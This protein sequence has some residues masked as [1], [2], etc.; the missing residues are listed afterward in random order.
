MAASFVALRDE[1]VR[2][3]GD[4]FAGVGQRLDLAHNLRACGLRLLGVGAGGAEGE[5]DDG[6]LRFDGSVE[7]RGEH[8]DEVRDE[9]DAEGAVSLG[10]D[11]LDLTADE[12]RVAAAVDTAEGAE[13]AGLGDGERRDGRRSA[14]PWART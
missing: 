13:A 10:A 9:A 4:S 14:W 8:R 3:G 5:G 1:D 12:V 2:A 7:E 11:A 6:G